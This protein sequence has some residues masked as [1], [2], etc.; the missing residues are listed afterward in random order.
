MSALPD[1]RLDSPGT[2]DRFALVGI[3]QEL[4]DIGLGECAIRLA[5]DKRSPAASFSPLRIA[6][7]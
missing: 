2:V 5:N 6:D 3:G 7:P 1:H 4:N